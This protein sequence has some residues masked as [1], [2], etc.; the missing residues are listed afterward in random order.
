MRA[1][2]HSKLIVIGLDGG[3]DVVISEDHSQE[4][5]PGVFVLKGVGPSRAVNRLAFMAPKEIR[6]SRIPSPR[7]GVE[8]REQK[9]STP[10]AA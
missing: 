7:E 1:L 5:L 8:P 2:S 10:S 6:I 3:P 9:A 4:I